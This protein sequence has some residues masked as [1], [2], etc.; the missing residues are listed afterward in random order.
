[1]LGNLLT[2]SLYVIAC[3]LFLV[4]CHGLMSSRHLV[5]SVVCLNVVQSSTYLLLFG[6]SWTRGGTVPALI[7][8]PAATPIVDPVVQAI[9]LAEVVIGA[10][11]T[12]LLLFFALQVARQHGSPDPERFRTAEEEPLD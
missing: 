8:D 3:W 5:H 7:E 9:T 6:I 2:V 1:M 12:M 4:G 11:V 10:G